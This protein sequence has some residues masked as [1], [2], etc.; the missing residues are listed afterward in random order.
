MRIEFLYFEGCPS[1]GNAYF[2]LIQVLKEEGIKAEIEMIKVMD[3]E[4]AEK[5]KFL[6]SPSIRIDGEDIE[7]KVEE[8][9]A[10]RCRIYQ[11][12]DGLHGWPSKDMIRRAVKNKI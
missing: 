8:G 10:M 6:G 9:Y 3:G 5:V 2:N 4:H 7:G 11:T 1:W 12:P